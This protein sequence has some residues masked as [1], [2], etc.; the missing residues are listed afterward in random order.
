MQQYKDSILGTDGAPLAGA[1]VTV[2]TAAGAA[3]TLYAADGG[4][5]LPSNVIT[6]GADGGCTFYAANGRYTLTIAASGYSTTTRDV[7]LHDPGDVGDVVFMYGPAADGVTDATTAVTQA[8]ADAYAGGYSLWW[9]D[10]T[11][12]TSSSIPHLHEVRHRGP[13]VIKRGSDLFPVEPREGSA[14]TLYVSP[15]GTVGAD[16]LSASQPM[17]S[18]QEA[19]DAL[20]NYGPMLDGDWAVVSAAGTYT[21]S[22]ATNQTH[23]V[24][25]RNYV[26]IRGPVAG[27]PTVPTAIF[28]GSG[29]SAYE[30]GLRISG[31]GVRAIVRDILFEDYTG[32]NSRIGCVGEN[33]ADLYTQNVHAADCD[34]CGIYA[35][36]TL[37]ARIAGGILD[38]CR[39]GFVANSANE[40]TIGYG[41]ASTADGPV[42][43]N[44]TQSAIYWSRGSQ[45]HVDYCK[46]EDSPVG[47]DID[48]A[49]RCHAVANDFKRNTIGVRV[50]ASA[51]FVDGA[52]VFNRGGA[53][54][55]TTNIQRNAYALEFDEGRASYS[56]MLVDTVR[57]TTRHTGA[58]GDTTVITFGDI[59]A[60]RLENITSRVRMKVYGRIVA[61][62][63]GTTLTPKFDGNGS[64]LTVL[65][66]PLT[67]ASFELESVVR[68]ASGGTFRQFSRLD[69][70]GAG[71]RVSNAGVTFDTTQAITP[72]LTINLAS[73]ADDIYVDR[74]ELYILG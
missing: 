1:T 37:H 20:A 59:D 42:V 8:V 53:D 25:S 10:G 57:A 23:T 7:L 24:P 44:A 38:G 70:S 14:N 45:G 72:T 39:S 17:A 36:G 27:H 9:A 3:A 13:G 41:A 31:V 58:T 33:E 21:G 67:N 71:V 63:A 29:G 64:A 22:A 68:E 60:Y 5:A 52:N 49:A 50:Q 69:I 47:L 32:S 62:T 65:G 16:G 12:L 48:Q 30:H 74:A 35:F 73:A 19:F 40:C 11:Y 61:G 6:T 43:T 46:I 51:A 56:E 15:S 2:T 34:W 26:T 18:F 54:A 28:S 66:A 55:N 4:S